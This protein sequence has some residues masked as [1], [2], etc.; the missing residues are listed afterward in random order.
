VN[1]YYYEKQSPEKA[2]ISISSYLLPPIMVSLLHVGFVATPRPE[3]M[4]VFEEHKGHR[5]QS[6][7]DESKQANGPLPCG[8]LVKLHLFWK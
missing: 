7:G 6:H 4:T 8:E 5:H 3:D 2:N 1:S